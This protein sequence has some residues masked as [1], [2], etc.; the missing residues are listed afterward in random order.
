VGTRPNAFEAQSEITGRSLHDEIVYVLEKAICLD[1]D[2][3][4]KIADAIVEKAC[5]DEA[6]AEMTA[7]DEW[8]RLL[9]NVRR[10]HR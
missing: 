9:M 6:V 8:G 10:R 7:K 3:L 5:D 4:T 1:P 2:E